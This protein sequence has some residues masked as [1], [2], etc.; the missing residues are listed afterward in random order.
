MLIGRRSISEWKLGTASGRHRESANYG[1]AD[2]KLLRTQHLGES[3]VAPS[4]QQAEKDRGV[5]FACFA[6]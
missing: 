5:R 3:A 6:V 2:T 1:L 4:L